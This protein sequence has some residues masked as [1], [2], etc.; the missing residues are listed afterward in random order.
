MGS[1]GGD[2]ACSAGHSR[3]TA[4]RGRRRRAWA[5]RGRGW[6]RRGTLARKRL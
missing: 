6:P 1:V 5:D 2:S 3:G 4:P